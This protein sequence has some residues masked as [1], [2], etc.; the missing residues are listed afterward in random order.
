MKI[1]V[2]WY[3]R[4]IIVYLG[5]IVASL[6]FEESIF[7]LIRI[8]YSIYFYLIG[9][10]ITKNTIFLFNYHLEISYIKIEKK[11]YINFLFL[12]FFKIAQVK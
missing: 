5:T 4:C 9:K 12:T 8:Y 6:N 7:I 3:S 11:K 2:S 1:I 10:F